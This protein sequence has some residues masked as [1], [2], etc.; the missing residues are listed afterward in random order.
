MDAVPRLVVP[1][2]LWRDTVGDGSRLLATVIIN[3][4]PVHLEAVV[5]RA[6]VGLF[7]WECSPEL[8]AAH[9]AGVDGGWATARIG[10]RDYVFHAVPHAA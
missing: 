4:V 1:A 6:D 7:A 5:V 9:A 3:D 2:E 8:D 10:E